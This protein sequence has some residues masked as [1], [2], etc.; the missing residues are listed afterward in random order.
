M[1]DSL[2]VRLQP[3]GNNP[4]PDL[5]VGEELV[6][7]LH[8]QNAALLSRRDELLASAAEFAA[9]HPT[10]DDDETSGLLAGII[11]QLGDDAKIAE[12][13]RE[14]VKAPWLA[15]GRAVD[16]FFNAITVPLEKMAAKLNEGQTAYQRAKAA[17]IKREA[18]E[19]ARKEREAEDARRR[20]AERAER[21]RQAAERAARKATDDAARAAAA[22]RQREANERAEA[23]RKAEEEARAQ[24]QAAQKVADSNAAERSRTR[25]EVA[26]ASLRTTYHFRVV[27]ITL[28][29]A[30]L[31]LV[32]EAMVK[33]M[34]RGKN[35]VREIP[36][37]LIYAVEESVNR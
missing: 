16:G 12:K 20:E 11:R 9:D 34:I 17:R 33:A 19:R 8:E 22:E 2:D 4:P 10:I 3:G 35:G 7:Q 25:G 14:G 13:T 24:R 29:P 1:D 26:M 27:D 32:N 36:G 18:E 5:K 30:H 28:V 37:L 15:G 6:E 21:E 23:A 31:L